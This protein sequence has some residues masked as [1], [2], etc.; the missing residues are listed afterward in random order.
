[1]VLQLFNDDPDTDAVVMIG[2]S[3]AATRRLRH[4]GAW[5]H[6]Q[7]GVGFIAASPLARQAD[8]PCR[9]ES[10]RAGRAQPRKSLR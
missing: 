4:G 1:M 9:R 7:A 10:S 2:K 5:A 6:E 3:A 8:G